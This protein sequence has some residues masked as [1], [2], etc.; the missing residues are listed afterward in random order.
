[1]ESPSYGKRLH[2]A[3][4]QEF[5]RFWSLYRYWATV[6]S[7]VIIP[8]GFQILRRGIHSVNVAD[9]VETGIASLVISMFGSY[10]IAMRR[11]AENLDTSLRSDID[12]RNITIGHLK[13]QLGRGRKT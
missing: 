4:R 10:V 8:M 2:K 5:R 11:G 6:T 3:A 7:A 9:T 12:D 1:M 13:D